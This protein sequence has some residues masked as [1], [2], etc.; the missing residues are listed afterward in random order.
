METSSLL[1]TDV[2]TASNVNTSSASIMFVYSYAIALLRYVNGRDNVIY[3][4]FDSHC[5]NSHGITDGKPG[6]SVL[7]NFQTLFQIARHIEEAY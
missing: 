7:I 3:F 4:L 6:F 1:M 2:F 5:R